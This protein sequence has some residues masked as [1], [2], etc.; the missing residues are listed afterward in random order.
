MSELLKNQSSDAYEKRLK[1]LMG[2]VLAK[3]KAKGASDAAVSL[4]HDQGFS[5]DVRMGD[6]ETVS[7]NEDKGLSLTVY[8][9]QKKGSASSTDTSEQSIDL[10]IQSACDIAMVSSED[11]CF[12]LADKDLLNNDYPDL[13][14]YHPWS[15]NPKQA[16]EM[17]LDCENHARSMDKRLT[18]SDGVNIS[19][20]EF[21]HGYAN[22]HGVEAVIKGT[23]HNMSC[24][25]IAQDGDSMQRNYDYTTARSV[26]GLVNP[27]TLAASAAERTISRLGA[28]KLKTGKIPI[29]F[30][31]RVSSGLI[32]NFISAISGSNL[33]KKN[34]FLL[35]SLEKQIFPAWFKIYEQPY[36]LGALGSASFDGEGVPTRNNIFVEQGCVQQYVLGSY[37]ARRM[38]LKTSANSDGVHNLTVEANAGSLENLMKTMDTGFLVTEL[39]GQGVNILT[40]NYSRGAAG[41]WVEKGKIQYPVEEVTIAGNLKDMFLGIQ[42]VGKDKNPNIATQCGS[43]LIQ[44]MMVAGD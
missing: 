29:L 1:N 18:N 36:L 10:L 3:T 35:D 23:R 17:A 26:Q 5:V 25:L 8:F 19:T 15:I 14:L 28:R 21:L 20:Y 40:G 22:T 7:F 32:S 38:G 31:S 2:E 9:G 33:Y 24:S 34:T 30:S 41:F 39:M 11:P 42:S 37:S 27:H 4:N 12:G 43:I 13:K 16:I 44:E 6:V